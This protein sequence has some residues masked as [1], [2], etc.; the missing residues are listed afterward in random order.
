MV[1]IYFSRFGDY[2]DILT[3]D[4]YRCNPTLWF[5]NQGGEEYIQGEIE[6]RII[7]SIDNTDVLDGGVLKNPD[8]GLCTPKDISGTAKTL[9]L[10]NNEPGY[11]YNGAHMGENAAP[12]LLEIG[13][14]KDIFIRSGYRIPFEPG[15]KIIIDNDQSTVTDEGEYVDKYLRYVYC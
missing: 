15:F 12:W 11:Y 8:Y 14:S 4:N 10:I 9:I 3:E 13:S 6:R 2:D 7:K 5:D 1:H